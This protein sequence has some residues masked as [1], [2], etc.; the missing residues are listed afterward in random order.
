[1]WNGVSVFGKRFIAQKT[2]A[3][4][5]NVGSE[6]C[7]F[8]AVPEGAGYVASKHALLAM[9]AAL[10]EE[11]P[12]NIKVGLICP[13]LVR[14]ELSKETTLGMNTDAFAAVVFKQI[15]AG[16][17]FIVSHAFNVVRIHERLDPLETAYATYAP[18]YPNDDAFD[19]R[20]L[21][22]KHNWY[23]NLPERSKLRTR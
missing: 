15:E 7:F 20:T 1:V 21:G 3:A 23:P 5:F 18:R 4:I 16:A 12:D 6:N 14:S 13:G 10:H 11:V 2:P 22:A 9:T 17:F 8:N 19:V